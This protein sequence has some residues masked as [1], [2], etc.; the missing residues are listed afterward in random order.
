M[1]RPPWSVLCRTRFIWNA[2]RQRTGDR[3]RTASGFPLAPLTVF[4]P[5]QKC[6]DFVAELRE[7]RTEIR[8]A[9]DRCLQI[10]DLLIHCAIVWIA[11]QIAQGSRTIQLV[12]GS[13]E[14]CQG[15]VL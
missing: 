12:P 15:Y 4:L 10:R 7:H 2:A 13:L 9:L 6:G 3:N 11:A 14:E 5:L 1:A 8:F